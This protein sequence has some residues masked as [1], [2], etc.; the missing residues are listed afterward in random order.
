[1]CFFFAL[2]WYLIQGSVTVL[3]NCVALLS[4]LCA[5]MSRKRYLSLNLEL[6][7]QNLAHCM[8]PV[9]VVEV[10]LEEKRTH[11]KVICEEKF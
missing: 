7:V 2:L 9:S 1:M 11:T 4:S 10:N 6:Q 8:Y 5:V 3:L